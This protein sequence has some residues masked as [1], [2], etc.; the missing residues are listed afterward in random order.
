M[1]TLLTSIAMPILEQI[2]FLG[3]YLL[4]RKNYGGRTLHYVSGLI[5]KEP[6]HCMSI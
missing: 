3:Q 1:N 2:V 5:N 4:L 6:S